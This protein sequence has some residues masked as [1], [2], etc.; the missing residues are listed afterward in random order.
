MTFISQAQQEDLSSIVMLLNGAYRGD[1]SRKGWT[2]EAG[3]LLGDQ[4]I[5]L[6]TIQEHIKFPKAI[7][8]KYL[9]DGQIL[10]CVFL[11]EKGRKLYLGLLCVRPDQQSNGIGKLL[12]TAAYQY[13]IEKGCESIYMTVISLRIELISWYERHGYRQTGERIPFE[14][15]AEFGIPTQPLDFVVLEQSLPTR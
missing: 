7:M 14:P 1:G 15:E 4:R 11:Q 8:L 10:G 2:T 6:P 13:A 3:L 12:L 9:E 5:D